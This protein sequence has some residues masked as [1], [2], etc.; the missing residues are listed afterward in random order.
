MLK[1]NLWV[2]SNLTNET[3]DFVRAI[4][5]NNGSKP[6]DLPD[7]SRLCGNAQ[8]CTAHSLSY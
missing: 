8:H 5:Y 4:V 1:A 2:D 7:Y 3:L 6:Q